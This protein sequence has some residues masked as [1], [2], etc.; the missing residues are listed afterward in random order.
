MKRLSLSIVAAISVV[1]L[2]A[3][4]TPAGA[5]GDGNPKIHVTSDETVVENEV[6]TLWV[7]YR[8]A[9]GHSAS[10]AVS[11]WQ[12]GAA[13]DPVS[14][15]DTALTPLT[16]QPVLLCDGE[17]HAAY[18]TLI[19]TGWTTD[20]ENVPFLVTAVNGGSRVHVAAT[21]TDTTTGRIDLDRD[22]MIALGR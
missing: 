5:A 19:Y 21:L 8:C 16:D 9:S 4:S 10:L 17:R 7:E 15:Y 3:G 18:V 2:I 11:L 13:N 14:S 12:G 20:I 6:A 22:R 1:L